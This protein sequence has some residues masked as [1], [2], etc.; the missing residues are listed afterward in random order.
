MME[1][2]YSGRMRREHCEEKSQ[3]FSFV[4]SKRLTVRKLLY[5]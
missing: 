3:I 5:S 1:K 4:S 2:G